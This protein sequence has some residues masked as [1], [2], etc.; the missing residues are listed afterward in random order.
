MCSEALEGIVRNMKLS[1]PQVFHPLRL[2]VT[3]TS[4]GVSVADVMEALGKE[5]VLARLRRRA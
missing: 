2:L 5:V 3:G 4:V 1:V